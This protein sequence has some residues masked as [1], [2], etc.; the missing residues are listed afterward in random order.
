MQRSLV[1]KMG[2]LG[3]LGAVPYSQASTWQV[4]KTHALGQQKDFDDLGIQPGKV[5]RLLV[6]E[7]W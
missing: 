3:C 6:S 7:G 1:T 2:T 4:M 5:Q